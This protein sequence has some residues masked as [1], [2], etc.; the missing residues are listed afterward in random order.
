M[1]YL[2]MDIKE[3]EKLDNI[4]F[5]VVKSRDLLQEQLKS[6]ESAIYKAGILISISALMIP[7]AVTFISSSDSLPIIKYVT[8]LPTGLMI[9]ALIFLLKV[10]MP[11]GL[12]HGFNFEQFNEQI[13][14]TYKDL[15]LFEIGANRDSYKDNTDI[16][17]RQNSN[18]KK[19]ILLIFF[20][21]LIIFILVTVSL[22][23]SNSDSKDKI[24]IQNA[25][26]ERLNINELNIEPMNENN[27]NADSGTDTSQT[28]QTQQTQQVQQT[29]QET[30]V[31]PSV[32]REQRA[33]IEK[34]D[35]DTLSKK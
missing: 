3:K 34:S 26:I 14:N 9:T 35:K 16:V 25:T 10:L 13:D 18:F 11:K 4:E 8:I 12:N 23:I 2:K 20:S 21:T 5:L 7:I 22:F 27:S 15:L 24:S 31:I 6:Y 19:G 33:I 1:R 32:T 29:T 30:T 28:Q 17:N